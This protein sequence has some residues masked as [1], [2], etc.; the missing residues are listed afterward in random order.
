[1]NTDKIDADLKIDLDAAL[2]GEPIALHD[3]NDTIKCYLHTSKSGAN[4]FIVEYED[5]VFTITHS[6][7][8]RRAI[9]MW[10]D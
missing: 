3:D 6:D 4:D 8:V 5:K 7:L 1:M 10:E 2:A 9:G